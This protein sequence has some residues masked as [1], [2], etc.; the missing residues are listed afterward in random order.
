LVGSSSLEVPPLHQDPQDQ[1]LK[2]GFQ[3]LLD[4][5]KIKYQRA[6]ALQK[7]ADE[8][9]GVFIV[10]KYHFAWNVTCRRPAF[11]QPGNMIGFMSDTLSN[12]SDLV[13]GFVSLLW[14]APDHLHLYVESDGEKSVEKMAQELKRLS[15]AAMLAQFANLKASLDTGHALW[16]EAYFVETIG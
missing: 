9:D 16:D 11:V 6:L 3:K 12:C 15:A 2:S 8:P 4:S 10:T 5:D 14:L 7:L 13:G 1:F